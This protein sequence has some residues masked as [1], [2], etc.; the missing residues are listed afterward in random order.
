MAHATAHFLVPAPWGGTKRSNVI[1][2]QL[3]SQISNILNQTVCVFSQ[4]KDTKHFRREF[5]LVSWVTHAPGVMLGVKTSI[6]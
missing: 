5:H 1:K 6:I 4:M 3:L 2:Y